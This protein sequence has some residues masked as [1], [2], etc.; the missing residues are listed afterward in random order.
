MSR[1]GDQS[2]HLG[3]CSSPGRRTWHAG[4]TWCKHTHSHTNVH[5]LVQTHVRCCEVA[6]LWDNPLVCVR[7]GCGTNGLLEGCDDG[8]DPN[9][10]YVRPVNVNVNELRLGFS[11]TTRN[12]PR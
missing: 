12:H 4:G 10:S 6:I 3:H 5:A 7:G 9:P 1:W 8:Y 2:M 11:N